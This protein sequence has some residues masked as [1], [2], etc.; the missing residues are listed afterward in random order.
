MVVSCGFLEDEMRQCSKEGVT[1]TDSVETLGVDLRTRVKSLGAK[2]K[3]R[4]KKCN[5]RF[6]L[7][8]RQKLFPKSYMKVECQEAATCGYDASKN[9]ESPCSWDG[10]H[11]EVEIEETDGGGSRQKEYNLFVPLHGGTWPGGGRGYL[12]HGHSAL[13][14]RSVDREMES[15]AERSVD[16]AD[17]RS[18]DVET[19]ERTCRSRDV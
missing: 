1:M 14:R 3:A 12:Y 6:F 5:V 2:E 13:G 15:Q 18:S 10:S 4:R 7:I 16:E 11:G 17:S 9:V 19:G 8:Q